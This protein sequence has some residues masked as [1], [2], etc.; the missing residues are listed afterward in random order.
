[1]RLN[2][3]PSPSWADFIV[4]CRFIGGFQ[5]SPIPPSDGTRPS[6]LGINK[7]GNYEELGNN[8]CII[9][10]KNGALLRPRNF[11]REKKVQILGAGRIFTGGR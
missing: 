5:K 1:M 7:S 11:L 6:E 8:N 2:P 4:V 3:F 10:V 9:R